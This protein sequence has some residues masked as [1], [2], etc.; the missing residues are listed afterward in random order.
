MEA[1]EDLQ[2]LLLLGFEVKPNEFA[3]KKKSWPTQF[4]M[5][6]VAKACGG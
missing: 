4:Y 3:N 1:L 2:A 5:R 6:Q